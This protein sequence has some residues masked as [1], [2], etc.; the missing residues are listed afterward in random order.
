MGNTNRIGRIGGLAVGLGI[1]AV[2]AMPGTA[3]ADPVSADPNDFAF[4]ID[5]FTL[6]QQGTATATSAPGLFDLALAEG[7]NSSATAGS[8]LFDLAVARGD[9]SSAA[10][11]G[12]FYNLVLA[13]G[14]G[15]YASASDGSGDY[16]FAYGDGSKTV[17]SGSGDNA[18]IFGTDS[19]A[20]VT[21]DNN[22]A[23][24]LGDN[25]TALIDGNDN[26]VSI[27]G[28]GLDAQAIGNGL[29]V[30]EPPLTDLP[31]SAAAAAATSGQPAPA[32]L[33]DSASTNLTDAI[34]VLNQI[35]VSNLGLEAVFVNISTDHQ[36]E[37]LDSLGQLQSAQETIQDTL[38]SH[39]GSLSSLVD[40]LFFVPL[41][42]GWDQHSEALLDADQALAAAAETASNSGHFA[43]QF[44]VLEAQLL[45]TGDMF[46]SYPVVVA[47]DLLS[48][49]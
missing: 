19:T 45:L 21:G 47:G 46:S 5:G 32:D 31:S 30:N 6:F 15:S 24:I 12:D 18:N 36:N 22:T 28:N 20:T 40:Q 34:Q 23:A 4:S 48:L 41:D 29:T 10:A 16:A 42:Q 38:S 35:D 44:D 3:S 13:H 9:D 43:A 8:G 1:G 14:D 2:A 27:I 37:L 11:N 39:D 25:D 33:L 49:F 17:V 26:G 7:A